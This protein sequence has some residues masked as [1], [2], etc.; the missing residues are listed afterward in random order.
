MI[1]HQEG[2][3]GLEAF[4]QD[5]AFRSGGPAVAPAADLV[6]FQ[7]DL[8]RDVL[9]AEAVEGQEDDG[10]ALL[11]PT[12][13]VGAAKRSQEILLS[14]VM[15]VLVALPGMIRVLMRAVKLA[16][17]GRYGKRALAWNLN[18]DLSV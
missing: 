3:V 15:V 5:K 12:E 6:A 18:W 2:S 17:I 1:A 4:D 16:K 14:L 10:G 8:G 7:T 11:G 9:V 13:T